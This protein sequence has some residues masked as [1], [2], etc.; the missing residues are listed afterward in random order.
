MKMTDFTVRDVDFAESFEA[1]RFIRETVFVHEQRVPA[2]LEWDD[3]DRHA[4]HVLAVARSGEPIGTARLLPDGHIGRMS[5][6]AAW[7]GRGVGGALLA[8]LLTVAR[9]RG[10]PR[11]LLNAQVQAL[12]FYR[13][14]GFEAYGEPFLD[15]DI[16]HR[17]MAL[18]LEEA[19]N[20]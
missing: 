8:H 7:R 5:V 16:P 11:V 13:K 10:F 15:A 9:E 4:H 17:S 20:C 1:I 12:D 3:D 2:E 18:T 14:Y 6:L 19:R